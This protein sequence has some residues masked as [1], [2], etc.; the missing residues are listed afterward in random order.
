MIALRNNNNTNWERL[1]G[2][3][4]NLSADNHTNNHPNKEKKTITKSKSI[5]RTGPHVREKK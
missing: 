1:E 2:A 5:T 3:L 4:S